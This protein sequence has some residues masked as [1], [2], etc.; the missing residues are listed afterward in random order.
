MLNTVQST[1]IISC[2]SPLSLQ[3]AEMHLAH[4]MDVS[5]RLALHAHRYTLL[6]KDMQLYKTIMDIIDRGL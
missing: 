1:N 2:K 4:T 5:Y 6:V 3:M